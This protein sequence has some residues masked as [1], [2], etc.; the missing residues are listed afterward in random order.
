MISNSCV[1]VIETDAGLVKVGVSKTPDERIKTLENLGGYFVL[2]KYISKPCELANKIENQVHK[3]LSLYRKK[4][5]YFTCPFEMAKSVTISSFNALCGEV[6][7][8]A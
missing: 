3:K 5:E 7:L 8:D 6:S 4:G 2:R 1:Y